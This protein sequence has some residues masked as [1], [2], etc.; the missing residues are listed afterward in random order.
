MRNSMK[1]L[2]LLIFLNTTVYANDLIYKQGFE[3][4]V[5]VA[6]TLSGLNSSGLS[7]DLFINQNLTE[8]IEL[9]SNGTFAFASD[10]TVGENWSVIIS[11]LPSSPQQGCS[12]NNAS[13]T[14]PQGGVDNIQV[15]CDSN[16]WNWNE[17][18]WDEGG[19]N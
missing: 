7:L 8:S 16:L 18:N 19:W 13:G 5:S 9:N 15:T 6:G 14:I 1:I 10:L 3:D 17:M 12:L 2:C 11:T 4:T